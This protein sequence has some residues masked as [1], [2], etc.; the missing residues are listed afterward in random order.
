MRDPDPE[1]ARRVAQA[2]GIPEPLGAVLAQRGCG[3]PEWAQ[4]FLHPRLRDLA[5]PF[6]YEGMHSAVERIERALRSGEKVAVFGDYDVDGLT[7]TA[8]LV[9]VL[10][11]LGGR[12]EPFVP[13]RIEEGY[14]LTAEALDRCLAE[15]APGLIVTV[16]CGTNA[17]DA[18][19]RARAAGV[20]VIVTDH[21]EPDTR[22]AAAVAVV[23]PKHG[24]P[25]SSDAPP[26]GVGVAFKLCHALLKHRNGGRPE[27]D[28]RELLDYVALGTVADLVPLRG[29]NRI[30]VHAGLRRL[31]R[32]KW[33]GV[34]ALAEAADL[35]REREWTCYHIGFVLGPRLNAAGRVGTAARALDLL[36]SGDPE[37]C[38]EGAR[39]LER[40]NTERRNME[41]RIRER[42]VEQV[43]AAFDPDRDYA[44]LAAGEGWHPGVLGIV[45]SRLCARYRRPAMV[46]GLDEEGVGRGSGRSIEGFDLHAALTACAGP[47]ERFG[48]HAL[49]AGVTVKAGRLE[50]FRAAFAEH[51]A[52]CLADADLR[53]VLEIDREASLGDFTP[54]FRRALQRL[55]P[56]GEANPEPVWMIRGVRVDGE[57]RVVG[58]RHWK[59][60][61]TDGRN[62]LNAIAFRMADRE[63]PGGCFDIV[64]RLRDNTFRGR[65]TP[66]LQVCDFREGEGEGLSGR[67]ET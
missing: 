43:D 67:A 13:H 58:D 31:A 18:V 35:H 44:V 7:A 30:L 15:H 42:A 37:A 59:F 14:G 28:L 26:A 34:R 10:R 39:E 16:D 3:E 19:E 57:P 23:N 53:P 36:L 48:G 20:D 64:G 5:D 66:Q 63:I 47:L 4:S 6:A 21:H 11:R 41:R 45:A 17:V 29:E 61:I 12:V 51:A 1:A 22:I 49:A 27:V 24:E 2:C 60:R 50:E 46:I 38:A 54:E 8:L 65:T 9:R 40:A 52:T 55:A 25:D 33:A 56:F 62:R 32:S